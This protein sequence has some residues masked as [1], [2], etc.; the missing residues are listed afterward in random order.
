MPLMAS[1]KSYS[2]FLLVLP[3]GFQHSCSV[4]FYTGCPFHIFN[5]FVFWVNVYK[6]FFITC[7]CGLLSS[8]RTTFSKHPTHWQV[9]FLFF[10]GWR[11]GW[12]QV[13]ITGKDFPF[14][15]QRFAVHIFGFFC[16]ICCPRLHGFD[17]M[18][19]IST[20]MLFCSS[21]FLFLLTSTLSVCSW[22]L[23]QQDCL[24]S[25]LSLNPE[26]CF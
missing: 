2:F 18:G 16:L 13:I 21:S 23:Q 10:W 17:R 15:S 25:C 12:F 3:A 4:F 7:F 8:L 5:S 11:A 1:C 9:F 26:P 14:L 24:V 22:Y 20:S 6:H 19:L